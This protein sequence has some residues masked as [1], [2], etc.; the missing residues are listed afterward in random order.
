VTG[1]DSLAACLLLFC[2]SAGA[3]LMVLLVETYSSQNNK[4]PDW[5][6]IRW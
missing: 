1:Q 3:V 5:R 4:A 2:A 6:E